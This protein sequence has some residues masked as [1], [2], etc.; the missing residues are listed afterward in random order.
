M[1]PPNSAPDRF[2][3]QWLAQG[4]INAACIGMHPTCFCSFCISMCCSCLPNSASYMWACMHAPASAQAQQFTGTL[5][6]L[7]IYTPLA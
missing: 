7:Q 2:C 4:C 6:T 3:L 5:P 1:A